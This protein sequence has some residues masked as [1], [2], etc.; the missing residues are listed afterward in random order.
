ML[1]LAYMFTFLIWTSYRNYN[2]ILTF[3]GYNFITEFNLLLLF[4]FIEINPSQRPV[5]RQEV[6][7]TINAIQR[8]LPCD[9]MTTFNASSTL[10]RCIDTTPIYTFTVVAQSF[11]KTSRF[12]IINFKKLFYLLFTLLIRN[13]FNK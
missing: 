10:V 13:Q 9:P 3:T 6:N 8:N 2:S 1:L 7:M 12:E 4:S 11:S 5:N